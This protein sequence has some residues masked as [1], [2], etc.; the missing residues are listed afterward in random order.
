[1]L[2]WCYSNHP[3]ITRSKTSLDSSCD[4][5]PICAKN[6]VNKLYLVLQINKI[7]SQKKFAFTRQGTKHGLMPPEVSPLRRLSTRILSF[8]G[9]HLCTCPPFFRSSLLN[10]FSTHKYWARLVTKNYP[11]KI[12]A[13]PFGHINRVL[14]VVK[15]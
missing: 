8:F 3:L 10:S 14:N 15:K 12:F 7:P 9:K 6:F 11:P 2:Q 5:Q 1:M 13:S 4:L